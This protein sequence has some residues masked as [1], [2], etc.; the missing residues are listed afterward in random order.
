V[1]AEQVLIGDVTHRAFRLFTRKSNNGKRNVPS[2]YAIARLEEVL[3]IQKGELLRPQPSLT[4]LH[5]NFSVK[6]RRLPLCVHF[7]HCQTISFRKSIK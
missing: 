3:G 6:T 4:T 5:W 2:N 7:H 1:K